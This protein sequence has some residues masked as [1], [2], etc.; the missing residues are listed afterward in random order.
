I[1]FFS[2]GKNKATTRG[3]GQA[4]YLPTKNMAITLDKNALLKSGL[5]PYSDSTS[6]PDQIHFQY[7]KDNASRADMSFLN[8]IAGQAKTGWTRPIYVAN[9]T[10]KLGLDDYYQTEGVLEKFVPMHKQSLVQGLNPSTDIDKNLN[11]VLNK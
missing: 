1:Q 10:A 5:V 2:S 3:G 8:I 6:I 11:L 4:N 9:G 7:S